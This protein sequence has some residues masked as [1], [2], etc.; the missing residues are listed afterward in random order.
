MAIVED[1][2]SSTE[3]S[4]EKQ[5]SEQV[6]E[7]VLDEKSTLDFGGDT[8]L[9][10]PPDLTPEQQKKLWRKIDLMLMPILTLMYLFSFLDRGDTF[11]HYLIVSPPPNNMV[12][13]EISVCLV[14]NSFNSSTHHLLRQC[15][16]PGP[17]NTIES[18]W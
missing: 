11:L 2:K 8:T 13:Q 14:I 7:A 10:P 16:A 17:Y 1:R 15:K 9:P 18:H 3:E 5:R 6:E 4:I 12:H